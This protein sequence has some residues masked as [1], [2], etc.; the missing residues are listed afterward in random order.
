TDINVFFKK[1]K[2]LKKQGIEV[3]LEASRIIFLSKPYRDKL[4]NEIISKDIKKQIKDKIEI[5]P[6]GIDVFW[7]NNMNKPI[8]S[9]HNKVQ[10]LSV[11]VINKR[12]NILITAQACKLLREKYDIN[13]ELVLVG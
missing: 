4:L 8:K 5:I 3:L 13:L 11:G 12:K 7:F 6:N 2:H 1:M 10:V 9:K